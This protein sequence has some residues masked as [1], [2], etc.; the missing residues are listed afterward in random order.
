MRIAFLT[1]DYPNEQAAGA[2]QGGAGRIAAFQVRLLQEAGH[3]VRVWHVPH[4]WA[5][6]SVWARLVLHWQDRKARPEIVKQIFEWS[7][8]LLVTHNLTGCGFGTP[9]ALQ[10]LGIRWLHV[11]HDVQLFDPS[12]Q[13]RSSR[14]FSLWQVVWTWIRKGEFGNPN[15]VLSP[16]EWLLGKHRRHEFFLDGVACE[17][18]PNPAKP[19]ERSDRHI[20]HPFQLLFV[21]GRVSPEKGSRFL[22]RLM[23]ELGDLA[24][25][26]VVGSG[27]GADE[28]RRLGSKVV[29]HGRLTE[30]EVHDLMRQAN[31]L[32]V[33]SLIEENQPNV[34][35]EAAT[36][37][38]PVIASD[39]GGISETMGESGIV[40][41]AGHFPSWIRSIRELQN[42]EAYYRHVVENMEVIARHHD[43]E[44]YRQRFLSLV[45]SNE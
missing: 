6:R 38:L 17:V 28:L 29:L 44:A 26:H 4:H 13:I 5:T 27:E 15:I 34:I 23:T 45:T 22:A 18:I 19:Y 36:H 12:G 30:E 3:E 20:Q 41:P 11:L 43:E 1:N 32:L 16:T 39:K 10:A 24:Q 9:R 42:N 37:G 40:C 14:D 2:T 25:L 35:L 8:Q 33:P 7:P 21:A 31:V